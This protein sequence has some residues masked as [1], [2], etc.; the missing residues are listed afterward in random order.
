MAEIFIG[1]SE[2]YLACEADFH[3]GY[4]LGKQRS[5][6]GSLSWAERSRS[7]LEL[8]SVHWNNEG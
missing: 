7:P 3:L 1:N 6:I 4:S 5:G 8:R 2:R